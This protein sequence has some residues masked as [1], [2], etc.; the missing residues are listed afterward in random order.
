MQHKNRKLGNSKNYTH[1]P[2]TRNTL[3]HNDPIYLCTTYQQR[4]AS[5]FS[6]IKSSRQ[7]NMG[8]AKVINTLFTVNST[9]IML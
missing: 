1:E 7:E 3:K 9:P 8:S 5:M 6:T 4:H 2:I